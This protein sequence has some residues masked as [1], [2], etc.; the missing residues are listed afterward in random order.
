MTD[1]VMETIVDIGKAGGW[2]TGRSIPSG[3]LE[4]ERRPLIHILRANPRNARTHSNKQR[5]QSAAGL[6]KF[7]VLNPVLVDDA[8]LILADHGRVKRVRLEGFSAL[9][10]IR[11]D[12]LTDA[13]KRAEV[14]ADNKIAEQASWDRGILAIELAN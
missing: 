2:P 12:R 4:V 5:R 10:V 1:W 6:R 9:P 13:Q 7:S 11:F 3:A 8:N 14:V